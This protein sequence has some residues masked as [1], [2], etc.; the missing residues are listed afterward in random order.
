MTQVARR[1]GELVV[2]TGAAVATCGAEQPTIGEQVRQLRMAAGLT[3]LEL[4]RRSG[5]TQPAI[6]RLELGLRL[7]TLRTLEKLACALGRDLLLLVS[8]AAT[9]GADS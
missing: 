7:P 6:A 9:G 4:A 5:S 8:A 2:R 1:A 3:Q